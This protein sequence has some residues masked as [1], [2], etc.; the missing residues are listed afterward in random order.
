MGKL[1][2][3]YDQGW[4]SACDTKSPD[5]AFI[6]NIRSGYWILSQGLNWAVLCLATTRT[7]RFWFFFFRLRKIPGGA[8]SFP[9]SHTQLGI[10]VH[11]VGVF[12]FSLLCLAYHW[13]RPRRPFLWQ[14]TGERKNRGDFLSGVREGNSNSHQHKQKESNH[15][16]LTKE[17][18]VPVPP[19]ELRLAFEVSN[20]L[21]FDV[22]LCINDCYF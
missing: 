22:T 2:N 17:S 6:T 15:Q 13:P 1:N 10:N 9:T 21:S 20:N 3:W 14:H 8:P 5:C 18:G 12:C 7:T 19:P 11:C 4:F 16:E